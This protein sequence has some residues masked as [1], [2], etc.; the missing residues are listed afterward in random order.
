VLNPRSKI[1]VL[2][3][4]LPYLAKLPNAVERSDYV[5]RFARKL[6]VEDQQLLA[7]VKKAA[8]QR[9]TRLSEVPLASLGS[10]K[11]AEKRLLQ[12]LLS[13]AD[14]QQRILPQ[15]S[16]PDFEGL[17]A[18]KIFAAVIENFH[19]GEVSTYEGLHRSFAGGV[20]QALLAQLQIEEVPESLT[21]ETA[22]NFLNALR[23]MRLA[24]YKHK[25]LLQIADAAQQKDDVMLNRL[26]EQRV[27][28]D[29]ELVSLSRK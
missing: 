29:R 9:R 25:I 13:D 15:C 14:L 26:I 28:V 2:N 22:Q 23:I 17:A 3:A 6:Q 27:L 8:Q 1:Q 4:V 19:R 5:F 20:E 21:A 18:E 7:E 11:L 24:S 16:A 10:M 12:L